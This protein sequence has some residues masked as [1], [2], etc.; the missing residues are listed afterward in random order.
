MKRPIVLSLLGVI[1][2][3]TSVCAAQSNPLSAGLQSDYKTIRDYFIRAAEKMP[4]EKEPDEW[5]SRSTQ[6]WL[7]RQATLRRTLSS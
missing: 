2:A 1:A 3:S 7:L 4:E 6:M 5:L